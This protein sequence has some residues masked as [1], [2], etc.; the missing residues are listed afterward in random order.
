[1]KIHEDWS[2]SP[3]AIR[4][5]LSVSDEYN[6]RDELHADTLN[7]TGYYEDTLAAING[8]VMHVYHVEG[9]GGGNTPDI[10]RVVGE[11]NILPS[12]TNPSNPFSLNTYDEETDIIITVFNLKRTVPTDMAFVH[13]RVRAETMRAEDV[14]HDLGAISMMG[15]D[16]QG[17]GRAPESAQ[18]SFQLAAVNKVRFGR[19]PQ[20]DSDNDNFRIKR[21]LAKVTINP[22]ICMGIDS[23]VGSIAP[24]KLADIVFWRPDHFIAKPE[25][26]LKGG[27]ITWSAMG[28]P[29]ASLMTAQPL[30]YRPQ[31]GY[32]GC[33]PRRLAYTFVTQAAID[34]GLANKIESQPL[35]PVKRT[36][37]ISKRDMV[38][39]DALPNIRIDPETYNVYVDGELITAKPAKTL[40]LT[41]LYFLR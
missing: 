41:Q 29:A 5:R 19:L 21:Y 23:Y 37:T 27:F 2:A 20:D 9:A 40:P 16:S 8:R 34:A 15:S 3:A 18:R 32:F 11:P 14:L 4:T 39:N 6:F 1:M 36:R 31:Y 26:I 17:A 35:L 24:G 7:E 28:D 12:S 10:M 33:N 13:G 25:L 30:K 38:L 22:A